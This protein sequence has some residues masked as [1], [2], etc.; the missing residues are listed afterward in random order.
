MSGGGLGQ[1]HIQL[2]PPG[3][4]LSDTW[5]GWDMESEWTIFFGY[6]LDVADRL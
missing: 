6:T 3:E 5:E 2:P 1:E 4:L